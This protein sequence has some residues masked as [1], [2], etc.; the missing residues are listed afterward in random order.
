VRLCW[1]S[2]LLNFRL[3][4]DLINDHYLGK[5]YQEVGNVMYEPFVEYVAES[6]FRCGAHRHRATRLTQSVYAL[7]SATMHYVG[8]VLPISQRTE[9]CMARLQ[10]CPETRQLA[11]RFSA[12]CHRSHMAPLPRFLLFRSSAWFCYPG[13]GKMADPFSVAGTA[14]GITSLGIQTFQILYR[15]YADFKG[16]HEDIDSLLRQITGLQGILEIL[17][18]KE[19]EWKHDEIQPPSLPGFTMAIA[20]CKEALAKLDRMTAKFGAIDTEK[21]WKTRL[22]NVQKRMIWPFKKE[23]LQEFDGLQGQPVNSLALRWARCSRA[24][25]GRYTFHPRCHSWEHNRHHA[26]ADTTHSCFW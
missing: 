1:A 21:H 5:H 26:R 24:T 7:I 13:G 16:H 8:F 14:V 3:I 23:T 19:Y 20:D 18:G 4:L 11:L 12:L 2:S 25:T 10:H 17:Q 15:Y 22:A 9:S 6:C